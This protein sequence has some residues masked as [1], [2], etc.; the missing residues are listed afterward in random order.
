MGLYNIWP[1]VP[2]FLADNYHSF[3]SGKLAG[4]EFLHP[5]LHIPIA[6]AVGT[7]RLSKALDTGFGKDVGKSLSGC[8]FVMLLM[9][10]AP[11]SKSN[12]FRQTSQFEFFG[13]MSWNDH[14]AHQPTLALTV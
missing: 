8:D 4:M 3:L 1:K 14:L 13:Q 6:Y 5:H 7:R 12:R 10:G 2:E 9:I 11:V